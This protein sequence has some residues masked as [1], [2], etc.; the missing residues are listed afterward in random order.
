M[1]LIIILYLLNLLCNLFIFFNFSIVSLSNLSKAIF[2]M[3]NQLIVFKYLL[4]TLVFLLLF[5]LLLGVIIGFI[6]V[7]INFIINLLFNLIGQM[8]ILLFLVVGY[9]FLLLHSITLFY[10]KI[11][12]I[13]MNFHHQSIISPH[14][15]L[16]ILL[17]SLLD[18]SFIIFL[19][20]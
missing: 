4:I 1:F 13:L 16:H 14:I 15:Y 11:L 8:I 7:L 12:N 18:L 20:L 9:S 2:L 3:I 19:I 5:R 17:L 6:I 10:L